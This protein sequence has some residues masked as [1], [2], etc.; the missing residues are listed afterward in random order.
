M[1]NF[2]RAIRSG[3]LPQMPWANLARTIRR[4]YRTSL[5]LRS[6][7]IRSAQNRRVDGVYVASQAVGYHDSAP[8]HKHL[9]MLQ[10]HRSQISASDHDGG[11]GASHRV[12]QQRN[13]SLPHCIAVTRPHTESQ[14]TQRYSRRIRVA[15]HNRRR[16]VFQN[17]SKLGASI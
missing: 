3:S 16:E 12:E 6:A 8:R 4:R 11:R 10:F 15:T 17:H 2:M 5:S 1:Y 13:R 9:S 14:R 7:Q